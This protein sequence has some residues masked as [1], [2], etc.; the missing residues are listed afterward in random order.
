MQ[1]AIDTFDVIVIGGGPAGSTASALLAAKGRRVLVLEKEK[2]PRYHVGE[3]LMPFCYHTLNRLGVID[4]IEACGYPAKYSVQFASEDGRISAPFYF[5]EHLDHPCTKTWQVERSE[6][7]KMLLDNAAAKGAEIREETAVRQLLK[8]DNGTVIGVRAESKD[9]TRYDALSKVVIDA[10]GRD[11]FVSSKE[12][13][14]KRDPKLNKVAIWTNFK[15]AKRDPGLDAGATTVCY[16]PEKGWFW[17][18]PMRNDVVSVGV[19]AE[20]DYLYRDTRDMEEILMREVDNNAWIKDHLEG[21]EQVGEWWVTG[22]YSYRS[23]HCAG[24]GLVLCGDAFSFLDPVFS[25]GVYLALRSAEKAADAVDEALA[26]GDVSG[27]QFADYGRQM[28]RGV[29]AMRKIVYA[30]YDQEFSFGKLVKANPTVRPRL[31]DCLIGD[32]FGSDDSYRDLFDALEQVADLPEPLR[33]GMNP[34]A[35]ASSDRQREMVPA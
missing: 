25:S 28:C 4:D 5:F 13:W 26:K 17:Y 21:S 12:G 16:L 19:V 7:D 27:A 30:F 34:A 8:D 6:F 11:C 9:G 22:E 33:H 15:G 29:E 2:F 18:I 14:R 35:S 24:D 31:T 1:P 32:I 20:R 3:S 10:S 23:E